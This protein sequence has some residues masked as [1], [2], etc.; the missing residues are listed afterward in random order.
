MNAHSPHVPCLTYKMP[1][2][3]SSEKIPEEGYYR[4]RVE[5]IDGTKAKD[6]K[7]RKFDGDDIEELIYSYETLFLN[8]MDELS[9]NFNEYLD[10]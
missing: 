4:F 1:F 10:K 6:A 8:L 7:F 5:Y 2:D 3:P 9:I